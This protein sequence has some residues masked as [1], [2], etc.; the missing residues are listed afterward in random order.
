MTYFM[1]SNRKLHKGVPGK[2]RGKLAYYVA[3]AGEKLDVFPHWQ[4]VT[5]HA[6]H[7]RLLKA[8]E[9]FP[10]VPEERHDEQHHVSLLVHGYSNDWDDAARRYQKVCSQLFAG[11]GS[12]GVCVLFSWPS[13]G[14]AAGYLPDR[15]DAKASAADFTEVLRELHDYMLKKQREA[16][17]SPDHA[18]RAKVSVIAHSMGNY[19]LQEAMHSL[20]QRINQPL[21]LSLV[22]ELIMVAADVD[23]DLFKSGEATGLS[24]GDAMANLT[25]RITALYSGLDKV[26]GVSAGLKHFGKRRLGRSGL[27]RTYPL[28]DNVW[29]IDCSPWLESESAHSAYFESPQVYALMREL[30]RG[31]NRR[32]IERSALF[33]QPSA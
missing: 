32:V 12:L 9:A 11:S 19:L 18:C 24:V 22:N 8:A 4:G 31:S 26:L 27:D 10:S 14:N 21:L 7:A 29:D 2:E 3:P 23:N 5:K 30:L 13:N 20:W 17:S 28:P 33:P 1:I 16:S 15:A 25:Y 6:F